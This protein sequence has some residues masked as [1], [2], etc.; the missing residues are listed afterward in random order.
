MRKPTGMPNMRPRT[1]AATGLASRRGRPLPGVERKNGNRITGE[2]RKESRRREEPL[3]SGIE[4]EGRRIQ[5]RRHFY[6]DRSGY[7]LRNVHLLVQEL[8]WL[9][10]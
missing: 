10:D 5:P 7:G 4:W 6:R 3:T 1:E 9:A 2:A 8:S